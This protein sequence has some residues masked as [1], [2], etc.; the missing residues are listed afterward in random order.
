V[1]R[2]STRRGRSK[3]IGA[4]IAAVVALVATGC[5]SGPIS[6]TPAILGI[7]SPAAIGYE[8][9]EFFVGGL[10]TAY[11]PTAPLTNDGEWSV[12]PD[13]ATDGAFFKTRAIVMRPADPADFDG[14]VFVEWMNV[15]AGADLP[16]DWVYGHNEMVRSGAVW[17]GV[18]AQVVGVNQIKAANPDRYASLV[19]PGDSYSYDIFSTVARDLAQYPELLAG[20]DPERVIAT[21]ESQSA[22]RLVTYIN[23]VHPLVDAY[24]GFLVHSRGASG[25][26]LTQSPLASVPTPNPSLIRDDLDEPVFVVQSEDDVIR[27][28]LAVRQP[29]T[30]TY[31]LWELA[32]TSHADAY[33]VGVGFTDVGDGQG[34]AA[35]FNLMRNPNPPPG[36]CA[37]SVNAGGHHWAFSAAVRALDQWVR[38]GTPPPTADLLE[39]ASPS[40]TVLERDEVGNALGGVRT[41]QVD[42]PVA[43][44]DGINSG[45]GFCPLFGSTTPLTQAQ[46]I[47]RHGDRAGF[48][49]AWSGAVADAQ[50]AGFVLPEDAPA[51]IAAAQASTVL[52][53]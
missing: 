52:V 13:P 40:P 15:S 2:S 38:T 25:S 22:G 44:V 29:D 42:A 3:H 5:I 33:M 28:R 35:M 53:P 43:R 10:A 49:A 41:P 24:D 32:G 23:A 30:D 45:S 4:A 31:R 39:V 17:I 26:P 46:L 1:D 9:Q 19:H 14:T 27:S 36:G 48:L 11:T 8:Q 47:A 16:N 7:V 51:L 37:A 12:V 6:G 50:A 20:L 18:S 21:G 34:A